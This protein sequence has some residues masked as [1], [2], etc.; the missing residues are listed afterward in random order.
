MTV[1]VIIFNFQCS[2]PT[3]RDQ[4]QKLHLFYIVILN[5]RE[6]LVYTMKIDDEWDTGYP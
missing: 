4:V 3:A 2:I 1:N 6:P 5:A